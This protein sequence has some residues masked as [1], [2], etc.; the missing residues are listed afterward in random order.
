MSVRI[1]L[2]DDHTII[3]QG[4]HSLLEKEADME[5]VGEAED[6]RKTLQLVRRLAPDI[7]VMDITMPNLNGVDAAHEIV[8]EFPQIK[9]IALS[10]HSHRHF[11]AG[12]LKAGAS[13][14]VL[15][16]CVF[17]EF[18]QAI[19]TVASGGTYLSPRIAGVVVED[20]VEHLT[21]TVDSSLAKLTDR[22]HEV[23][24]LLA[25]GRSTK[26]IALE[27]HVSPKT[28]ESNRHNIMEK[29]DIHSVAEL[30][31]YAIRE[32][33]TSLEQ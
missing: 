2:A 28:I 17:D 27:L 12:M 23:L 16:E 21:A 15:K 10:I 11:V 8:S 33:L 1:L 30:T 7:V 29:L 24:Q 19:R 25:E 9:V 26:Q 13:G 22:E 32:G 31:K 3:R 20:Y 4:L 14:Y 6:G 5:V 18:V